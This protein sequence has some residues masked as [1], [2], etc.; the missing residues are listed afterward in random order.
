[1]HALAACWGVRFSCTT[2]ILV[3]PDSLATNITPTHQA[4][5]EA[6]TSGLFCSFALVSC[7]VDGKPTAAIAT[8]SESAGEYIITPMFVAI[9]PGMTV[10]DHDGVATS[11]A[12]SVLQP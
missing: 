4:Q 5:F 1:M 6:L 3:M 7:F 10:K 8:V 2:A 11:P 12:P 9:A